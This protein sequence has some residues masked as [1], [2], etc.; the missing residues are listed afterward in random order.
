M[1]IFDKREQAFEDKFVYDE[2]QLFRANARRN[3][4]LGLWA[5]AKLGKTGAQAEAYAEEV[6]R[7][8]IEPTHTET[9]HILQKI[10]QDFDAAG[11]AQSDHQIRRRMDELLAASLAALRST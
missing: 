3:R 1:T 6:V 5:A 9:E 11:V 7:L 10:R 2:E 4:L 8:D